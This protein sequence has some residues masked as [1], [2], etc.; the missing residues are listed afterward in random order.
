ME[1]L[2]L[3]NFLDLT[4]ETPFVCFFPVKYADLKNK[5]KKTTL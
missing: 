5:K 3:L 4:A 2:L 1:K